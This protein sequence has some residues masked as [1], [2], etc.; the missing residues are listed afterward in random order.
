MPDTADVVM[1]ASSVVEDLNV[2]E[3]IGTR[4]VALCVNTL[5]N[6]LLFQ[7]ADTGFRHGIISTVATSAHAGLK[8]V[9]RTEASPGVAAKLASLI[10]MDELPMLWLAA[11][12]NHQ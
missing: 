10:G 8:V 6:P 5:A 2:I 3:Y 9:S 1:P 4:R 7:A 12:Y 11:P